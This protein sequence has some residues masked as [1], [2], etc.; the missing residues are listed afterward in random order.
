LLIPKSYHQIQTQQWFR[1]AYI[2]VYTFLMARGTKKRTHSE[3]VTMVYTWRVS[4]G[5][6]D[7]FKEWVHGITGAA[8]KM[9]GH[10][11]VTTLRRPGTGLYNS[12]LRFDTQKHLDDWLQSK[13]RADW[14]KR[15]DGVASEEKTKLSG[16]ETWFDAPG[17]DSPPR[18][19]MVI[20]TF[21]C[22]YPMAILVDWLIAPHMEHY[23]L[24]LRALLFPLILPILLTYLLMPFVTQRVLKR[25]LYK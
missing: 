3:P 2:L 23:N 12:V 13:A 22:V 15:L 20:A 19:K 24:F 10:L 16:L 7:D 6:D 21:I 5:R 4:P 9:P 18:W 8:V 11:G 25:W 14:I 1:G 17:S